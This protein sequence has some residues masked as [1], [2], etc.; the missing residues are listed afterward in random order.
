MLEDLGSGILV[1][2]DDKSAPLDAAGI[3]GRTGDAGVDED[4][5]PYG[6]AAGTDHAGFVPDPSRVDEGPGP[7]DGAA[8]AL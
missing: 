4:V 2:G 7:G 8:K 1:D 3:L 5:G 6:L